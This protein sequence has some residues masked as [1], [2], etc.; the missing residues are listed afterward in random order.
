MTFF[1]T[2]DI[3]STSNSLSVSW[4]G[5][6]LHTVVDQQSGG[7]TQYSFDV[8]GDATQSTTPLQFSYT[9]D[10]TGLLLDQVSVSPATGPATESATGSISFAD[11]ETGDTHT[12][13]FV[14]VGD[15]Y[16]G[17]FSLDP[18]SE[19]LGSGSVAWHFTVDNSDIQ[20]LSQGQTLTQDYTV[21]VTDDHGVSAAQDVTIAINGTNDAPTAN[22]DTIIT[23]VDAGGSVSIPG[24]ALVSNDSDPDTADVLSVTGVGGG[25]GGI[26]LQLGNTV[27]FFDDATL[28]GSFTY[29]ATDGIATSGA[30]T[31]TV[32]NSASS[33][34]LAGTSGDDILIGNNGGESLDGAG[35]NDVLIGNS[36]SHVLT[37]GTGN[38]IFAFLT[39]ADGPNSITDFNNT[40]EQD[41]IAISASGFGAGL[42][43]GMDASP[44]FETSGDN[45]FQSVFSVFHFDTANQTLY[46]SADGGGTEIALAQVQVGVTLNPH[47]L[48]IV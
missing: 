4:D 35:G 41:R 39:T 28:G 6:T 33:A 29:Q 44:V 34:T 25:S 15:G 7:F 13:S 17:T 9:D 26:P 37:G 47:D 46:Y 31:A 22:A 42:S 36:G 23:D 10:G 38:D 8:V 45:A 1:A 48:L 43:A 12:A 21:F 32:V 11:I 16:V 40:T 5:T 27:G 18:V 24:W 14:P 19:G 20:F 3:E 30:V 2:G